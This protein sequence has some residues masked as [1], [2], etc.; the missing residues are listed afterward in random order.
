MNKSPPLSSKFRINASGH[1]IPLLTKKWR[2]KLSSESVRHVQL[3]FLWDGRVASD[4]LNVVSWQLHNISWQHVVVSRFYIIYCQSK[5]VHPVFGFHFRGSLFCVDFE[6]L[7]WTFLVVRHSKNFRC[8]GSYIPWI[9][10]W[11]SFGFSFSEFEVHLPCGSFDKVLSL[12]LNTFLCAPCSLVT[13]TGLC[14][15]TIP[16][17]K[18]LLPWNFPRDPFKQNLNIFLT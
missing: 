8:N 6:G 9:I 13:R 1:L 5:T 3:L 17:L 11:T 18:A 4:T 15:W 2:V 7:Y 14:S 10:S 12:P 16:C